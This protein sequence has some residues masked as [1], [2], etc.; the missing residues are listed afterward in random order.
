MGASGS[1]ALVAL[2]GPGRA[3][4]ASLGDCLAVVCRGG[5][6]ARATQQH[7]VY[8]FGAD[9]LE[10]ARAGRGGFGDGRS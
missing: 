8:G 6:A 9:V 1:T 4:F 2:L 5:A 7:R 3:L 10:G